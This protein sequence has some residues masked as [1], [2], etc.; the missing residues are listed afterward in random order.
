M[1]R[2]VYCALAAHDFNRTM[3]HKMWPTQERIASLLGASTRQVARC[4][5]QLCGVGY[6]ER[7]RSRV[8]RTIRG[9]RGSYFGVHLYTLP[10]TPKHKSISQPDKMSP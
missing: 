10:I 9:R 4:L 7:K 8:T 6:V 3:P 2:L 1:A 5:D